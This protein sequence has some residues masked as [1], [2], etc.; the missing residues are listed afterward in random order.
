M[1]V[2]LDVGGVLYKTSKDTLS[3]FGP[4]MLSVMT[5]GLE[6]EQH[7]PIFI[8]RNGNL[9]GYVLDFLRSGY[10]PDLPKETLQQL[11]VEADFYSLSNMKAY[12]RGAM[13]EQTSENLATLL[14]DIANSL[15][16][17]EQHMS[18]ITR[19]F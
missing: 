7:T 15:N 17:M 2:L 19:S 3:K 1:I 13:N 12:I 10:I 5:C 18:Y 9:F 16:S 4:S 11:E 14:K 8:D 6:S